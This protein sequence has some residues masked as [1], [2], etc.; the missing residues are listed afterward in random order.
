MTAG[1]GRS[2]R[3]PTGTVGL[4]QDRRRDRARRPRHRG[5]AG[6]GRGRGGAEL[7]EHTPVL[8]VVAT[9]GVRASTCRR[10]PR[11][12]SRGR[13]VVCADAWTNDV[14]ADLG[15]ARPARGDAGAGDLLR[16][17]APRQL[18][19]APT[20]R[21]GSGWTTRRTTASPATASRPS[22]PPR[23]AADRWST[24]RPERGP[25]SPTRRCRRGSRRARASDP[26]RQSGQ[27]GALDALPVH[28]D[29]RPR[30]RARAGPRPRVGRRRPRR[31][32]RRSSSR[33]RSA[34]CSPTWRPTGTTT[35]DLSPFRLDRPAL[36]D[37]ATRRTG[38]CEDVRRT[39][40]AGCVNLIAGRATLG[41]DEVRPGGDALH[42]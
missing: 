33:R 26:A 12:S 15:V 8:S 35:T 18:R 34:G 27:P 36:T 20:C 9:L 10:T 23:T 41:H 31:G 29:P 1:A 7:R 38:W 13:V 17:R 30:L 19:A 16:A 39:P 28:A 37:P 40:P 11:R 4:Y 2:S 3:C 5:D 42:G 21:C 25:P 6:P 24:P 32:A 22:R 14:L